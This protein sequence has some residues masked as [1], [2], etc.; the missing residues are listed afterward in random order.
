M[1]KQLT[2]FL[3]G[4]HE[5][6]LFENKIKPLFKNEYDNVHLYEYGGD[7]YIGD[8][9]IISDYIR[10]MENMNDDNN[11]YHYIF[12]TDGDQ[13]PSI[14]QRIEKIM[15]HINLDKDK[16]HVVVT[17]IEGWYLGGLDSISSK[18][19]GLKSFQNTDSIT[20]NAFEMMIPKKYKRSKTAF[21]KIISND[22]SIEVA[23][24][25]NSSFKQFYNEYLMPV[26]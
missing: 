25:K 9:K 11:I 19:Y 8:C 6:I 10:A 2:I 3:E 14:K 13:Y 16:I 5:I 26:L 22:F 23:K 4:N 17:E 7:Q 21:R 1:Y 15:K 18:K 12:L 20:K 24:T